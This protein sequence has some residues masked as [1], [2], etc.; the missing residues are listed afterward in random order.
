MREKVADGFDVELST[1][2]SDGAYVGTK[3]KNEGS[4]D[5]A[6]VSCKVGRKERSLEAAGDVNKGEIVGS[7]VGSKVGSN[8]GSREGSKEG[9]NDGKVLEGSN[10][11][12]PVEG[13]LTVGDTLAG[14]LTGALTGELLVA[15][16]TT[17]GLNDTEGT[18]RG[19]DDTGLHEGTTVTG[20]ELGVRDGY[21]EG[22]TE[23]IDVGINEGI[24]VTGLF[25]IEVGWLVGMLVG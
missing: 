11:L 12:T 1:D 15:A 2:D 22:V 3:V 13:G 10:V 8:E 7:T 9:C 23:G 21:L 16:G 5:N 14:T 25:W 20:F 4:I 19:E 17:D 24:E 18:F 6:E